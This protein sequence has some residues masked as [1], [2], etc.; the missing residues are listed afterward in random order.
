MLKQLCGTSKSSVFDCAQCAGNNQQE[1]QRAGCSNSAIAEWCAGV[2]S[3]PFAGSRILTNSSWGAEINGWAMKL[4]T[5]QWT[6]CFS[7]FS[8][9]TAN[10]SAF[11][12]QC[13]KHK[14]EAM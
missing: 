12:K 7:S 6:R 3:T 9:F 13:D 5:Q 2:D 4:P 8:D 10:T 1:L 14:S 11:H